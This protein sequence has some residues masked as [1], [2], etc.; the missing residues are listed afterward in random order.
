MNS[1]LGTYLK[2][3]IFLAVLFTA[4]NEIG[5]IGITYYYSSNLADEIAQETINGF[6]KYRSLGAA[7]NIARRK[8]EEKGVVFNDL[9]FQQNPTKMFVSISVPVQDT[10]VIHRF[11]ITK[12]YTVI[13]IQGEATPSY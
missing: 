2:W 9:T 3:L 13:T 4:A 12:P 7:R 6:I 5:R 11:E 8:A 1:T 10:W